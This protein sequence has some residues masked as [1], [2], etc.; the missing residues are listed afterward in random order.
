[1]ITLR[2]NTHSLQLAVTPSNAI[3]LTTDGD[4]VSGYVA[5]I[6]TNYHIHSALPA[7]P[8]M[9]L[10]NLSESEADV[11]SK[12]VNGMSVQEIAHAKHRTT[13]TIRAQLKSIMKKTK[14]KRQ[15]DLVRLAT[16]SVA[17]FL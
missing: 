15:V 2:N 10:F 3:A 6:L 8:L 7:E 11:M 5:V 4:E 13:D 9:T 17:R 12:I 14:T 1:M 16:M